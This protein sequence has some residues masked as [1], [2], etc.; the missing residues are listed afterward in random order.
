V[1]S[2]LP[3]M[4]DLVVLV[5]GQAKEVSS[6]QAHQWVRTSPLWQGRVDRVYQRMGQLKHALGVADLATISKLVWAEMWEMHSLFHT[7]ETPFTYFQ[8]DTLRVLNW[9]ST[10]LK[11]YSKDSSLKPPI[12]TLDAGP[13]IHI[14]VESA[15]ADKWQSSLKTE[16]PELQILR[17][18]QGMGALWSAHEASI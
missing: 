4:T 2:A 13:N 8:P 15:K 6:S 16:F 9:L 11:N 3:E 14:I 18:R 10:E 1:E 5:S 7:C 17:D 12:V